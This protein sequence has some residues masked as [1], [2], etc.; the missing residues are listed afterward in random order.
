MTDGLL[1]L[2][3]AVIADRFRKSAL[4][5]VHMFVKNVDSPSTETGTQQSTS[6]KKENVFIWTI[7]ERMP[8]NV[9]VKNKGGRM[10]G[11]NG[12][13]YGRAAKVEELLRAR[14]E[15]TKEIASNMAG[16]KDSG[17]ER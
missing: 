6:G 12:S 11:A 1:L 16:Y 3:H 17:V 5:S 2:K 10:P 8:G 7:S 15:E 9:A 4:M 13:A 14:K